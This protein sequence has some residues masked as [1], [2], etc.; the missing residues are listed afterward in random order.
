MR[1]SDKSFRILR[2]AGMLAL[3][4]VVGV[5]VWQ[6]SQRRGEEGLSRGERPPT[7]QMA[8][9]ENPAPVEM[10]FRRLAA[11]PGA[12]AAVA[13]LKLKLEVAFRKGTLTREELL[14]AIRQL[15]EAGV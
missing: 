6:L 4:A 10:D 15:K 5:V 3:L 1:A 14:V 12:K 11:K 9:D 2:S 7:G 13:E 8:K